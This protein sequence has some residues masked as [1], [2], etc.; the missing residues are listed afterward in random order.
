MLVH[1]SVTPKALW[2]IE[3]HLDSELSLE[4]I[5]EAA[6]VSRFHLS[7]AFASSLGI[8]LTGYTRARRLSEAARRLAQG[9]PIFSPWRSTRAMDLTK[10]SPEPFASTL[11]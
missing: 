8:S 11:A 9:A 7:R 1:V 2:Y 5:A 10:P 6:G 4:A 3:S